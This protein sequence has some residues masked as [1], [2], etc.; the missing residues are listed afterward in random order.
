MSSY[1]R[2][3]PRCWVH[4]WRCGVSTLYIAGRS[5]ARSRTIRES[6]RARASMCEMQ[7]VASAPVL[8]LRDAEALHADLSDV[9]TRDGPDFALQQLVVDVDDQLALAAL[10]VQ[11]SAW[12]HDGVGQPGCDEV[13]LGLALPLEDVTV[14]LAKV[15]EGIVRLRASHGPDHDDALD[16]RCLGRVD[17]RLLTQPVHLLWVLALL[18]RKVRHHTRF[19]GEL[20]PEDLNQG[21][22]QQL[23][24]A[25]GR[26]H[27]RIC[28]LKGLGVVLRP[29][30]SHVDKE[31][32]RI[33]H[34]EPNH[35]G[36]ALYIG[37][38]RHRV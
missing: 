12:V 37:V 11:Q 28:A 27:Q 3:G 16:A 35:L 6:S 17:L 10:L 20:S 13:L 18:P 9:S 8:R 19:A 23:G 30:G 21:E 2:T 29:A 38:E 5:L 7:R 24:H 36:L 25:R 4:K 1:E 15:V 33:L 34:A 26:D 22:R 32:V 14:G 31:H